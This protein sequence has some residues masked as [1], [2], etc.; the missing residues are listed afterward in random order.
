M[1]PVKGRIYLVGAGPGD[2]GLISVRAMELIRQADVIVHDYLIPL[3]VLSEA[4]P[5]AEVRYCGKRAGKHSASQ[6]EINQ[7]IID[8][9]NEGN[10]VV[11]LKGGDPFVFGRGGEEALAIREAGLEFEVVCG[12]S[13]GIAAPVYAGIPITQRGVATSLHFITGHEDPTKDEQQ[14]NY[15]ALAKL[16]GTLVFFMGVGNLPKISGEL[17]KYGKSGDTPSAVIH[18]GCTP[19]QVTVTGKLSEIEKVA[20]DAGMEPPSII[21]IGEVVALREQ[22]NWFETAPLFG[23]T[24]VVT[25]SRAQASKLSEKL[26]HLGANVIELPVIEIKPVKLSEDDLGKIRGIGGYDWVFFTSQNAV[27]PFFDTFDQSGMDVRAL[28][29]VRIA[30]IGQATAEALREKGIK[31]DLVPETFTSAG[32]LESFGALHKDERGVRALLP[33][34]DIAS[35]EL[36][37]GLAKLRIECDEIAIYKTVPGDPDED[38]LKRIVDGNVDYITFTSSSTAENFSKLLGLE[39]F[40]ELSGRV[41]FASI[42]PV[43]SAKLRELGAVAAIEA[44]RSDIDGLVDA[45]V[46]D[47]GHKS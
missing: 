1:K 27:T 14:V 12:V 9:A 43:T 2:P 36:P 11:R 33:R 35:T 5:D 4:R 20:S 18:W 39:R 17:M 47:A 19:H 7:L 13:S 16:E 21:V 26:R 24:V 38:E 42:G 8:K 32:L 44:E 28:G 23:K 37:V 31:P 22:L 30:A 10:M 34:A 45:I 41:R 6:D 3:S 15:E 40:V 25:R 29:G 46:A